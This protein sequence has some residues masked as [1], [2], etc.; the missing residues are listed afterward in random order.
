[1][2]VRLVKMWNLFPVGYTFAGMADG[3]AN[4]LIGRGIAEEVKANASQSSD[5]SDGSSIVPDNAGPVQKALR[6]RKRRYDA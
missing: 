6:N 3:M 1:M 4:V 5:T 2:Q